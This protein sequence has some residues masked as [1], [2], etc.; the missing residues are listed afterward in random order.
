KQIKTKRYTWTRL[1]RLCIHVLTNTT[2]KEM[3]AVQ[4][5]PQATYIRLLGMS[6]K[7]QIY[8]NRKKKNLGLPIVTT[9]SQHDD[10]LQ[11]LDEWS[12]GCYALGYADAMRI[13]K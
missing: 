7:G 6:K 10:P 8:L 3:A 13:H 12:P 4:S 5:H 1:Q 2:K 11:I 9:L